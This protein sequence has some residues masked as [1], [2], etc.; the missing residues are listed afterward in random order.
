M[1]KRGRRKKFRIPLSVRP[2]TVRSAVAIFLM[3]LAGVIVISSILGDYTGNFI[4]QEILRKVFG[5]SQILLAP[6]LFISGLVLI[7]TVK[8]RFADLRVL[9]GFIFLLVGGSGLFHS[10]Y[11]AER[12]L[13]AAKAGTGGG[14]L[15]YFMSST[16]SNLISIYGA[17]LVFVALIILALV[18]ML[19]KSLDEL[20]ETLKIFSFRDKFKR[21]SQLKEHDE[22]I[23]EDV[24]VFEEES[25]LIHDAETHAKKPEF[26]IIPNL[27]EPIDEETVVSI[28]SSKND[29]VSTLVPA[30]PYSD[31]VYELP[32]LDLLDDPPNTPIDRG[33]VNERARTIEDTL[34][35][36]GIGVKVKD[37]KYG[38]TVTQYALEAE[39][40]TKI[41]KISNLQYDLALA[42]ASPTGSVRIE[43]PIPGRSLVG[44]E[45]PN[46]SRAI[47]NF[48]DVLVSEAMKASKSK[49]ALVLG[50]DV[51]GRTLVYDIG[52]MPHLLI[53]GATGSGKSVFIH[54]L[55]FSI[56][57]RAT[58][59]ECKFILIDPKRVELVH[60][61]GI[62]HLLSPVVTDIDKAPSVF[63]WAVQ[64]MERRYKL[65]EAAKVRNIADY[66]KKSGFQA[67]PYILIVVDELAEIM[68]TDPAAVEKSIIRLAQL[69]RAIGIH[70]IL[71]L[72]RPTTNIITGLIKANVPCRIA[73]NVTSG[74]DSR[75]ILDQVGAEKLLGM[76][77]MLFVPPDDSKPI[78]IQ[79]AYVNDKEIART[80]D[81]LKKTG[82]EPEFTEEIF[83]VEDTTRS[84]SSGGDGV[85]D[86]YEEAVEIIQAEGKAS[87]SLLQR[88]L[89]I[90][91]SRAARI[92]DE[93]EAKGIVGPQKGSKPR[94][95]VHRSTAT[96]DIGGEF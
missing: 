12:A 45:V 73:F 22:S 76:G 95:I 55:M 34:R 44:I 43:A 1:A 80:V 94:E 82:I 6:V 83:K 57:Y 64:E 90:G 54:N 50:K 28:K 40:G 74:T 96:N 62:P 31:K 59:Q 87:A 21:L 65:L 51:G 91:Y 67:L 8:W 27:A 13:D 29:T 7:G 71:A 2:E 58:P 3:L 24:M 77:D 93:M 81:F 92:I 14:Y 4:L 47:V 10:F 86:L 19:D 88:R 72:Q 23:E 15:G 53:A 17:I 16:L 66:N 33:D 68:V 39:P 63:K 46:N 79:G 35:S 41:A 9:I 78:R 5:Y 32:P 49:L 25:P 89:S 30:L 75:V 60:Y 85:D 56:L 38:P 36:F 20:L 42:L 48:K 70:L 37:M 52:K 61:N 18:L 84:I 11:S 69:A 26:E